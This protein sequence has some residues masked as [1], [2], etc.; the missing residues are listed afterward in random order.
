LTV[1]LDVS[2]LSFDWNDGLYCSLTHQ[3]GGDHGATIL[4]AVKCA[5]GLLQLQPRVLLLVP[6][7][8]FLATALSA[9][10]LVAG[11]LCSCSPRDEG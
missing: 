2:K 8:S 3:Q 1:A 4:D 9:H 6:K 5:T 11:L 7:L 10:C